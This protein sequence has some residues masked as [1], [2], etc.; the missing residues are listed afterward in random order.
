MAIITYRQV[1][2]VIVILVVAVGFYM[3]VSQVLNNIRAQFNPSGKASESVTNYNVGSHPGVHTNMS[4]PSSE[5]TTFR[6]GKGITAND[7]KFYSG[8][9]PLSNVIPYP[10]APPPAVE[11][12]SSGNGKYFYQQAVKNGSK[13]TQCTDQCPAPTLPNNVGHCV[14]GQASR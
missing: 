1:F 5:D 10:L 9:A 2:A 6:I 8:V 4:S 14:G 12:K 11:C 3:V 13:A 7:S